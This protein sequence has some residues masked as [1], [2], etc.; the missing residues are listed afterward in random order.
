MLSRAAAVLVEDDAPVRQSISRIL[1]DAGYTVL[2]V[3][4]VI[5]G[6]W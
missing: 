1:H 4:T 5:D 2:E 6:A 3:A